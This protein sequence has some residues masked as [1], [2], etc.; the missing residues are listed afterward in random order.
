[1]VKASSGGLLAES[2]EQ[3][4][5]CWEQV[6]P[7]ADAGEPVGDLA[8]LDGVAALPGLAQDPA[9]LAQ[10]GRSGPETI[11]ERRAFGIQRTHLAARQR[12]Q[13]GPPTRGQV[14]GEPDTDVR[15]QR[16]PPRRA[17]LDHVED[18]TPVQDGQVSAVPRRVDEARERPTSDA[19]QRFLT[20]EA[21]A[22]L[23]GGD[24]E[25]VALL[26]LEVDDEALGDHRVD[27]VVGRAAGQ[28]A[29]ARDPVERDRRRLA[30]QEAQ[31]PQRAGG[32]RDLGHGQSSCRIS[33]TSTPGSRRSGPV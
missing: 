5:D 27:Q 7:R 11:D 2:D 29:G 18:V 3:C 17:L 33:R 26:V 1:M 19:L 16:R 22:H 8:V 12:H 28:V 21:A 30:G 13:D 15:H 24:P 20:G 6:G 10:G 4:G 14:S 9:Q 23:E 32:G 25:A 31:H